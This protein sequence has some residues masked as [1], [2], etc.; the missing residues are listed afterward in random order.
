MEPFTRTRNILPALCTRCELCNWD[1]I[2]ELDES[3]RGIMRP[4]CVCSVKEV[5]LGVIKHDLSQ[6]PMLF[7]D[8]TSPT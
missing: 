8:A 4:S 7:D 2:F 6:L 1:T 3:S 5:E